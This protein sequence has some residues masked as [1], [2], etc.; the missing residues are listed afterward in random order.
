[1]GNTQIVVW[2]ESQMLS[3][4]EGFLENCSL[5]MNEKDL[6]KYGGSSFVVNTDWYNKLKNGELEE[7]EYT[8]E[9]MESLEWI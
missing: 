3:E 7:K 6:K 8:D 1:M 5:I 2:P 4:Y 9:E